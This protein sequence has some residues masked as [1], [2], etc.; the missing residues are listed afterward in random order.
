MPFLVIEKDDK[1]QYVAFEQEYDVEGLFEYAQQK[2]KQERQRYEV[3]EQN[4][5][6]QQEYENKDK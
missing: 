5:R 3:F 1:P 2:L 6:K 4:Y